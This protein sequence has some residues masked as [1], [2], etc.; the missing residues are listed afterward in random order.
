MDRILYTSLDTS[1]NLGECKDQLSPCQAVTPVG[2]DLRFLR[3]TEDTLE[4]LTLFNLYCDAVAHRDRNC[5]LCN[6]TL[7]MY[8]KTVTYFNR[9]DLKFEVSTLNVVI[10]VK[11]I[12][13]L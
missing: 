7:L 10:R 5:I 13:N 2:E 4:S 9:Y 8:C 11:R 3:N 1:S 12:V 6:V